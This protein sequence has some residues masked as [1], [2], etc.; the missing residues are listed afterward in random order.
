MI[1]PRP[2]IPPPRVT[3]TTPMRSEP[4]FLPTAGIDDRVFKYI[5]NHNGEISLSKAS[6][7][8]GIELNEL[9]EAVERLRNSGLLA[10]RSDQSNLPS[11]PPPLRRKVCVNCFRLIDIEDRYCTE[12][13]YEQP[14]TS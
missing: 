11:S 14:L 2:S 7:E 10:I 12:C 3:V 5:E 6:E 9:K 13:G 8:I 1:P 4:P